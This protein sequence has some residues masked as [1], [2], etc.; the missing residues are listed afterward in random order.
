MSALEALQLAS[1]ALE[2]RINAFKDYADL[3][4][5]RILKVQLQQALSKIRH[6]IKQQESICSKNS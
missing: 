2:Y 6:M 3:Y 4:E 5:I 1:Y